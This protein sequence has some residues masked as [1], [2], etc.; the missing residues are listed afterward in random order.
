MN[1][2]IKSYI[3]KTLLSFLLLINIVTSSFSQTIKLP[4]TLISA[5]LDYV[6][7]S[8][9]NS[10]CTYVKQLENALLNYNHSELSKLYDTNKDIY[11]VSFK[12]SA[13]KLTAWFNKRGKII[14]TYEKYHNVRLPLSVM[15]AAIKRYPDYSIIEDVV[16]VKYDNED[17]TIK[18]LYELKL[19]N[20]ND[21]I[22]LKT[23]VKGDFI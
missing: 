17:S 7:A 20:K 14:K 5:N 23:D 1:Q 19:K 13:G 2:N 18:K 3:M 8:D 9:Y 10:A 6:E 11:S 22:T 4:E 15:Q 12:T 21:I 16:F